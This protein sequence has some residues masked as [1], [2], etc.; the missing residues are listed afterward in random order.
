MMNELKNY[1]LLYRKFILK[2]KYIHLAVFL[3]SISY[4]T[5]NIYTSNIK[6]RASFRVAP[7]YELADDLNSV[8]DNYCHY[9]SKT[10]NKLKEYGVTSLKS[11]VRSKKANYSFKHLKVHV[12]LELNVDLYSEKVDS[13]LQKIISDFMQ[14]DLSG[15]RGLKVWEERI[16]LLKQKDS[17]NFKNDSVFAFYKNDFLKQ[18]IHLTNEQVVKIVLGQTIGE[19]KSALKPISII[20]VSDSIH[21][22]KP[23]LSNLEMFLMI[24]FLPTILTIVLGGVL[25]NE[26]SSN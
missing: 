14:R 16:K 26:V 10:A 24:T 9:D 18:N 4:A 13:L 7:Y 2:T 1:L 17:R 15:Y 3:I 23:V 25:Y 20:S 8:I 11:K 5:Y 19:Y 6:Y 12:D 21:Q 22:V